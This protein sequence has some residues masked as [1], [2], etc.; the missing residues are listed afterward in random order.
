MCK[1]G[2]YQLTRYTKEKRNKVREGFK[3]RVYQYLA[4]NNI[5]NDFNK[6]ITAIVFNTLTPTIVPT[7]GN[8]FYNNYSIK[9][10]ITL[11][12]L[13]LIKTAKNIVTS[14]NND[15]FT[16]SLTSSIEPSTEPSIVRRGNNSNRSSND[17]GKSAT[18]LY[19][20]NPP[21][22]TVDINFLNC[23]FNNNRQDYRCLVASLFFPFYKYYQYL[24]KRAEF[25]GA[26]T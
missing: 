21:D 13:I 12:R 2:D 19:D 23:H 6:D 3:R 16:Y 26:I 20:N 11:N 14:I 24:Y 17:K 10:F 9:H 7:S 25:R 18:Y 8:F 15:A 5:D 4:D 1:E 22:L